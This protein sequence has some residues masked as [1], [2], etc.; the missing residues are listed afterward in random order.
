MRNRRFTEL[1]DDEKAGFIRFIKNTNPECEI[2]TT[3]QMQ[4][5]ARQLLNMCFQSYQKRRWGGVVGL[6]GERWAAAKAAGAG[7]GGGAE[8]A[9]EGSM[10]GRGR[11]G[12]EGLAAGGPAVDIEEPVWS[13]ARWERREAEATRVVRRRPVV[14]TKQMENEWELHLQQMGRQTGVVPAA[15]VS[16]PEGQWR[17]PLGGEAS[18]PVAERVDEGDVAVDLEGSTVVPQLPAQQV[19]GLCDGCSAISMVMD[20]LGVSHVDKEGDCARAALK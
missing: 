17:E 13:C 4:T 3:K 6:S 7:M 12:H 8:Q 10:P 9:T 2:F 14:S 1:T 19:L 18:R 20:E 15:G 16:S 11:D 5:F